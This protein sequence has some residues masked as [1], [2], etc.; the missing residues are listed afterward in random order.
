MLLTE[1]QHG[2]QIRL[3]ETD[4]MTMAASVETRVPFLDHEF[5][6][7]A[8]SLPPML[9]IRG[10]ERK[11]ILKRYLERFC[12]KDFVYRKKMGF[13]TPIYEWFMADKVFLR[14]MVS[15]SLETSLGSHF[16][17]DAITGFL[18][19]ATRNELGRHP[20]LFVPI[21]RLIGLA[22]WWETLLSR[23]GRKVA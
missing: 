12:S 4:R 11:Y 17:P 8:F 10:G 19:K 20:D 14:E 1:L 2:L 21:M 5:V 23:A 7:F 22:Y 6:E 13:P 3:Q 9:K 15:K 18:S 16:D